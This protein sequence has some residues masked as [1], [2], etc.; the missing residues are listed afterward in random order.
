MGKKI[1]ELLAEQKEKFIRWLCCANG[2]DQV[3]AEKVFSFIEP[4]AGLWTL[5]ALMLFVML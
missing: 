3:L 5:I 1:Q 2:I 4:F